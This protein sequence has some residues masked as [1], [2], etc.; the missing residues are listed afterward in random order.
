MQ[1][2]AAASCPWERAKASAAAAHSGAVPEF[3]CS[4]GPDLLVPVPRQL[5]QFR[6]AAAPRATLSARFVSAT[7][8]YGRVGQNPKPPHCHPTGSRHV[9]P[10]QRRTRTGALPSPS[11]NRARERVPTLQPSP[12]RGRVKPSHQQLVTFWEI[13]SYYDYFMKSPAP[14]S[15]LSDKKHP[16]ISVGERTHRTVTPDNSFFG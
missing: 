8:R 9:P 4:G 11:S 12:E 15:S 16:E 3:G 5:L 7:E 10:T 2:L 1:L 13:G 6:R 14:S